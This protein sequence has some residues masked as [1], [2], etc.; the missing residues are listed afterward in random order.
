VHAVSTSQRGERTPVFARQ[1]VEATG[2]SSVQAGMT[3]GDHRVDPSPR[4]G[5]Q[6]LEE[7]DEASSSM[8]IAAEQSR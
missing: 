5:W 7:I 6:C 4:V 1:L 3:R 2:N 8:Q